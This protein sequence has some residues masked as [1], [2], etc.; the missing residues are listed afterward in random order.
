MKVLKFGGAS[1][2][3]AEAVRNL[4]QIVKKYEGSPLMLI[5]SAMGKTTNALEELANSHY[6]RKANTESILHKIKD[7]HFNILQELFR[8]KT[9]PIYT[10]IHNSFVEIEWQL[11]DEPVGT[12]DF[13]YDQM[14]S[15]GEMLSTKIV[16]AYLQSQNMDVKWWDVRDLIRTDNSYRNAKVDWETTTKLIH[17]QL[18]PFLRDANAIAITQGFVGGTSENFNATLGREGSDFSAAIFANVLNAEEM[19]IW[20]DVEGMLNADPKYFNKTKKLNNISY[21]EAVELAYYG[22]S[23]IHPKT[24]KPLENKQI[25][26]YVKSFLNPMA[27]GSLI[28]SNTASDSLVPSYIFKVNQVLISLSTKDYSFVAEDSLSR[29]FNCF[30]TL[31]ISVHLMQNSAISFSVCIDYEEVKFKQLLSEL[32]TEFKISFNTEVELL[33]VRH[34]DESTLN[35]LTKG[36]S[37]LVEQRSRKTARLV[38]K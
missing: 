5:I 24:I 29:I 25:P 13:E 15:I 7:F 4:A 38:M 19:I 10:D 21:L 11:E 34:Y 30:S 16:Y 35:S 1:V 2:K 3:D 26:L 27:A 18:A 33:T 23:I 32:G 22:A 9:H 28:N 14:V 12:F 8:E 36:K 20:K 17:N 31:G 37:I 6:Y